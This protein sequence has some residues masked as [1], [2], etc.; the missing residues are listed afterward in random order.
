MAPEQ[1]LASLGLQPFPPG[2]E[3]PITSNSVTQFDPDTIKNDA[4]STRIVVHSR[5]PDLIQQFLEH[6]RTHGSS[7][8]KAFYHDGWTWQQQVARLLEKRALVFLGGSDSTVLRSGKHIGSAYREWDNVGTEDEINNKHLFLKEYLSYDEIMLSSLVG[9]SGPS[10]FINDGR[11]VNG[12]RRGEAGTFE[13]RGIIIGLV[14]ARFERGDRMDSV[15]VLKSSNNPRQHPELT[16]IFH[17]FF[18]PTKNPTLDFD[19]TMYKARIRITADILLLEANE[20][21]KAVGKKAYV[22]IVGLG[23]GV[24]IW[25]SAAQQPLLYVQA[26][27][28]SLSELGESLSNIGTVEF[29]WIQ[30]VFGWSQRTMKVGPQQREV[31]V[32]FSRRNPAEKLVGDESDQLLVLSYAWDGNAFPGNE[33]WGGSLTATGDPAAAC[34]ST[35]SELHNAMI[36]PGFLDR[37]EV[38]GGTAAP[39]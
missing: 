14:G 12:G 1:S 6:K 2:V 35:I 31:N 26:F 19:T 7:V 4:L 10:Y 38:L 37:I 25:R 11:R 8:E 33:Y 20:R 29:A 13:P 3:P 9:V 28:E 16:K 5:F 24:W 34:M 23:L 30:P 17:S 39:S 22:Y 27:L 36:N 15:H 21:A 18:G 32:K